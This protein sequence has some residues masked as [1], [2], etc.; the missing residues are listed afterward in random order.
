MQRGP[1]I[2]DGEEADC[3]RQLLEEYVNGRIPQSP[4]GPEDTYRPVGIRVLMKLNRWF[5]DSDDALMDELP[6]EEL[7]RAQTELDTGVW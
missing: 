5:H 7:Q 4:C 1:F 6:I 3:L 2:A